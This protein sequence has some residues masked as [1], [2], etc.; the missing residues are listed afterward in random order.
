MSLST[1]LTKDELAKRILKTTHSTL[2]S[3]VPDQPGR[4]YLKKTRSTMNKQNPPKTE[5]EEEMPVLWPG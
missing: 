5:K 2:I 3:R 1:L 4:S